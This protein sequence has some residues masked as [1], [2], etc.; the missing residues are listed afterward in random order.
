MKT[1]PLT[2]AG[3]DAVTSGWLAA[4]AD[5][6]R[7]PD[8][9][10]GAH[11]KAK[12]QDLLAVLAAGANLSE[13]V[14][15]RRRMEALARDIHV[16]AEGALGSSD[17]SHVRTSL[18]MIADAAVELDALLVGGAAAAS[19]TP[20]AALNQ[21][22]QFPSM[23]RKM[24]SGG[25]VQRWIDE[26]W[27]AAFD[28]RLAAVLGPVAGA[29]AFSAEK[30]RDQRRK[31]T[32]QSPYINHPL[33]LVDVLVS[34]GGITDKVTLSAAA[35]HDTI[36]DVDVTREELVER[37]GAEVASVVEEVTDDKT[38]PKQQRKQ[39]QIEHAATIS[40]PAK[41]VKLADKICN[42]RDVLQSP[43]PQ[44]SDAR[45]LEYANWAAA[46]V[47]QLRGTNAGLE[48]QFDALHASAVSLLAEA[49]EAESSRRPRG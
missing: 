48:A 15:L 6:A 8:L 1:P 40:L 49:G 2:V 45:R 33:Q 3:C 31:D 35:L 22:P 27:H 12:L 14:Q 9:I 28:E 41:L 18:S 30:H 46:V 32:A 7:T 24:W 17:T 5:A 25:E 36:E 13:R 23:L 42:V 11:T 37:F 20:A 47:D 16:N 21:P 34:V 29:I 4:L 26:Q 43:P 39:L 10:G 38:L 19:P 44:W